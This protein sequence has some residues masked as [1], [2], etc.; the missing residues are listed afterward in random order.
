MPDICIL[1]TISGMFA[2]IN[3]G[4]G[5][6]ILFDINLQLDITINKQLLFPGNG[7]IVFLVCNGN[8]NDDGYHSSLKLYVV[9]SNRNKTLKIKNT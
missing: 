2:F 7:F 1:C 9:N 5:K 6:S 8:Q 3:M 4:G